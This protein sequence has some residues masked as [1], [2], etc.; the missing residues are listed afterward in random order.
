M[1]DRESLVIVYL[2]YLDSAAIF[3]YVKSFLILNNCQKVNVLREEF[4]LWFPILRLSAPL[5]NLKPLG[6]I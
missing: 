5:K 6:K 3:D 1:A 2:F 4:K